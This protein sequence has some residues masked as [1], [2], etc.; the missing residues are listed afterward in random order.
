MIYTIENDCLKVQV[1]DLG[2]ELMSVRTK[3]DDCEYLWQG[4]AAY[5][6]GRAC[7]LFPICGRLV[8]NRY[9]HQGKT[10]EMGNHGFT[11]HSVFE[12]FSQE[13]DRITMTLK[14][15]D[16]TRA[17]Y[18]FEFELRM[19]Y[20]LEGNTV[21]Q[22]Y[23]VI[24][25]GNEPMPFTVGGHPGFNVPLVPGESFEDYYLEFGCVKSPKRV[26]MSESCHDSGVR[27]DFALEDGKI[28]R[29]RHDLFDNDGIFLQDMCKKV[30]LKSTRSS[31]FVQVHYPQM[32]FV[33]FWHATRTDAPYVCIEPWLG[34]PAYD[35]QV[36]ELSTKHEMLTA[37]PGTVYENSFT[38]TIGG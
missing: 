32:K 17:Q 23:T 10:Y 28:I 2:A 25:H 16:T 20:A 24:N 11:R 31:K 37:A 6:S 18:P 30:T 8:G 36:D 22:T 33:G 34:L 4:D 9:T 29:L 14:A 19:T 7:V 12:V 13:T 3:A 5:W 27:E 35:G 38:M 1:A 21:R 26:I 15:N